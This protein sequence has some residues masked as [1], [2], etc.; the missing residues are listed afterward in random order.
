MTLT[1]KQDN[2]WS[3]VLCN[4]LDDMRQRKAFCDT[5]ILADDG[6]MFTAHAC[7]LAAAS[8]VLKTHLMSRDIHIQIDGITKRSWD[9]LLQFIYCGHITVLDVAEIE[10]VLKA[11]MLLNLT[12][13]AE[14]CKNLFLAESN[15]S[16]D[17]VHGNAFNCQEETFDYDMRL[18]H[19]VGRSHVDEKSHVVENTFPMEATQHGA[20]E[21]ESFTGIKEPSETRTV[22]CSGDINQGQPECHGKETVN[23]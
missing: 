6:H 12:G 20:I 14:L 22:N 16:S 4:A 18:G 8:P 9:V 23:T 2:G 13:L 17:T 19:G 1:Q 5:I 3:K 7:I 15:P 10:Q 21:N 11:G